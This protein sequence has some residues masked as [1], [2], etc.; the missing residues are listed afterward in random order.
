MADLIFPSPPL[1]IGQEYAA[2]NGIIYTWDGEVWSSGVGFTALWHDNKQAGTLSPIPANRSLV[3]AVDAAVH[4]GDPAAGCPCIEADGNGLLVEAASW[5]IQAGDTVVARIDVD[6]ATL[7]GPLIAPVGGVLAG[8]LPNPTFRPG[9]TLYCAVPISDTPH[10]ATMPAIPSIAAV[11]SLLAEWTVPEQAGRPLYT[12]VT[13]ALTIQNIQGGIQQVADSVLSLRRGGAVGAVDGTVVATTPPL[14]VAVPQNALVPAS[15]T[16]NLL[17]TPTAD[18]AVRWS[19]TG[20]NPN[21]AKFAVQM[22][23]VTGVALGFA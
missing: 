3:L 21:A 10:A 11:E 6:G 12:Q 14:P 8:A 16:F 15:E 22:R 1:T 5:T 4:F 20:R 2:P 17:T 7:R 13:V 19:V 18:A 23:R 9:A